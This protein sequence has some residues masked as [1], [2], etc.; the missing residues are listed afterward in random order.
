MSE[1]LQT[2]L[3]RHQFLALSRDTQVPPPDLQRTWLLSGGR[4]AGKTRAGAEWVRWAVLQGGYRRVALVGPTFSD[5][6]EVMIEGPSGIMTL[7]REED[8]RPV[9]QPSRHRLEWK[10]GA[11]AYAF[12]AE[13][14]DSLRGPQFDLAW[15]DEAG[16]WTKGG[17]VWD[18]LQ[19]ALRLGPKPLAMVTTTPRATALI[20]RLKA[21]PGT[22]ETRTAT[23]DNAG[24][25][26]PGFVGWM[27]AAYGGTALG[28]QELEGHYIDDPEGAMFVRTQIDRMRV[29]AAPVQ[30]DDCIVA[31]DPCISAKPGADAC[32]IILAGV[33]AGHGYVMGDASAP[34]LA[35]HVWAERAAALAE[36]AGAS[37]ILAEAN[38][39]GDMVA[40]ML[41]MTGTG[42]PVRLVTARLGK[43]GRAGPVAALYAR[44]R[45]SH[46]GH[47]DTL[48]DQMC[49]FGTAE[50]GGSPDRVDALVWALW[51]LM[52]EPQGPRVSLL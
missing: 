15:C 3:A 45:V 11:V 47:F 35:P 42:V 27:Q 38:Q 52:S 4:G 2:L 10:N 23:A 22:V 24:N 28:R 33:K 13:D 44:G 40:E 9:W 5:V 8:D 43:R 37:C 51:A 36:A 49:R 16:A 50:Q 26:S 19:L 29:E 14:P 21:D 20:R 1:P 32:G 31:V 41:R 34:G 48:E 18:N 6:R 30:L 46:A 12:S 25:L 17:A 39:G 7:A